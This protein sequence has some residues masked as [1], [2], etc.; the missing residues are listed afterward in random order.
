[1]GET[2]NEELDA[3]ADAAFRSQF[4]TTTPV[5]YE[6]HMRCIAARNRALFN[7]GRAAERSAIVQSV[8]DDFEDNADSYAAGV[9]FVLDAIQ[10]R[11]PPRE[12]D[13]AQTIALRARAKGGV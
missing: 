12:N 4:D 8:H 1:M 5:S 3:I 2:T 6:E 10:S 9:R 11:M 13:S 7:A